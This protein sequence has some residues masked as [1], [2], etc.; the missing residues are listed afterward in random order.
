MTEAVSVA[1]KVIESRFE[2]VEVVSSSLA[3]E[4]DAV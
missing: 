3:L 4:P 2:D 1:S